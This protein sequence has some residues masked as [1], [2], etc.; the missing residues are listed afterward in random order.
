MG[1]CILLI[2]NY[3]RVRN[4]MKK[5]I[6]A[7]T[8]IIT[9]ALTVLATPA[10]SDTNGLNFIFATSGK[11][12]IK[13]PRWTGYKPVY[14][15]TLVNSSDKLRLKKGTS[16]KV[17]CTNLSIWNVRSPGESSVSQGCRSNR[18]ILRR[19]DSSTS[20]TRAGNDPTIPYLISPRSSNILT[21]QPK[22]RWNAVAG[23]TKY[24]VRLF[25]RGVD[26]RTEINQPRVVYSGKEPLKPGYTYWL[27]VTADNGVTTENKD[28]AGFTVMSEADSKRVKAEIAQLQ[29]QG[30]K[31]EGNILALAHLYR[32]NNLNADA[33]DLL[34]E[35]VK[36]GSR[37]TAVYQLL[38]SIYQQ[39]EL[40]LL[41]RERYL[42]ALKLAQT[43]KNL[44]AQAIIQASLGEVDFSLDK[45]QDALRWYQAAQ[46][47]Y[48]GLGD[49][50]RVQELQEKV[51]DLKG[52]V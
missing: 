11:V 5:N 12:E 13:R 32:S 6:V 10:L 35:L 24:Q 4:K 46:V 28:N 29:Q 16:A 3:V 39:V 20:F 34:E 7:I 19:I 45:L 18:T 48:R 15:G 37:S 23:A 14:V 17:F 50:A 43:E 27:T 2:K 9:F 51:D 30:L 1:G 41:A 42:T 21:S 40:N 31:S 33:I 47:G 8:T 38:G 49:T 44:E 26:W 36:K 52:R 25:G 22:L